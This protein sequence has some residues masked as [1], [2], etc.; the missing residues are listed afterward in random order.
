MHIDLNCDMGESFGAYR[1]G[2]D[3]EMM[4]LITSANVACGFHAG[5]PSVM[6]HTVHLAAAA[7][8]S[9]G[10]HPG[11]PDLQGFGRRSMDLSAEEIEALVLYQV[12][13]LAAFARAEGLEL[14]HVK[15]HGALYNQAAQ[16]A[17]L[18]AAIARA[19]TRFSRSLVLVGLAGSRLVQAGIEAGLHVASEGFPDRAYNPD[20]TLRSRKLPGAVLHDP[21]E[22]AANALRLARE[23]AGTGPIDTLCLHGDNPAAVENARQVRAALSSAGIPV[24]PLTR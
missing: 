17:A 20:G 11:F 3:A 5:D 16:D 24:Q 10:A 9:V 22:V 14:V 4:P 15:P 21:Q 6:A 23:G 2:S 8:V 18:A 7:R 19:V 12:G 13:A 1:L